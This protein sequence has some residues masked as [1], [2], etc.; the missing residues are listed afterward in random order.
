MAVD[1][2]PQFFSKWSFRVVI[3][4]RI[5]LS[6]CNSLEFH[7]PKIFKTWGLFCNYRLHCSKI[8][9]TISFLLQPISTNFLPPAKTT[10]CK[11]NKSKIF[12]QCEKTLAKNVPLKLL[13][14]F[15]QPFDLDTIAYPWLF[16][17]YYAIKPHQFRSHSNDCKISGRKNLSFASVLN[18][19]KPLPSCPFL[20]GFIQNLRLSGLRLGI[21]F[22]LRL[23]LRL[24]LCLGLGLVWKIK[25]RRC[26][27][28][29]K[30]CGGC[31][32]VVSI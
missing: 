30:R 9:S 29:V 7:L 18:H 10:V 27:W 6:T 21:G 20:N 25:R 1:Y 17:D 26:R 5:S 16:R 19:S 23:G 28:L 24:G 15:Y 4:N 8:Q 32:W 14:N 13:N 12:L 31:I 22:S 3:Q 2:S 11:T